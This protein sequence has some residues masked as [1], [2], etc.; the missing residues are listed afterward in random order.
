M[1]ASKGVRA[2]VWVAGTKPS[3]RHPQRAKRPV[4]LATVRPP[5]RV[6][7]RVRL[8]TLFSYYAQGG[9]VPLAAW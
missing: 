1:L 7:Q 6:N 2:V 5:R 8:L 9:P 4:M 3:V